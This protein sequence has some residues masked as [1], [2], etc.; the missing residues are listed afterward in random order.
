[1]EINLFNSFYKK[2]SLTKFS[3]LLLFLFFSCVSPERRKHSV[4]Q[5][6]WQFLNSRGEYSEAY[7]TDSTYISFHMI[8]GLTPEAHYF[9]RNDTLFS[10]ADRHRKGLMPMATF[11]KISK[12]K[13]VLGNPFTKDT[14]ERI[15]GEERLSQMHFPADSA[16]FV[17]A[18]QKRYHD[19]LFGKGIIEK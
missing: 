8:T 12:D 2:M 19:F 11:R 4:L 14:L 13:I 7:F 9:L 1:M 6:D 3:V 18:F 10:N 17:K 16:R 15:Q 5:G